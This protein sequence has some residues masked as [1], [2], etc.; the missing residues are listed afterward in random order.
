MKCGEAYDISDSI[1]FP[2]LTP[3]V[4]CSRRRGAPRRRTRDCWRPSALLAFAGCRQDPGADE[5]AGSNDQALGGGFS[6]DFA[7]CIRGGG[8]GCATKFCIGTCV[9]DVERC[10]RGGGGACANKCPMA[11]PNRCANGGFPPL[12][13]VVTRAD[14]NA[15]RGCG[16]LSCNTLFGRAF[17]EVSRCEPCPDG[18]SDNPDVLPGTLCAASTPAN[19]RAARLRRALVVGQAVEQGCQEV[20]SRVVAPAAAALWST[21][22]TMPPAAL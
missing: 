13:E 12:C 21:I 15:Q 11:D 4:N 8:G 9:S 22:A 5:A 19:P 14:C 6:S 1:R 3:P 7:G 20:L 16:L 18:T 17:L 10:A 2:S